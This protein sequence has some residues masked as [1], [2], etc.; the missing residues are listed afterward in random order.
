MLPFKVHARVYIEKL[1]REAIKSTVYSKYF[2][3]RPGTYPPPQCSISYRDE[4]IVLCRCFRP[5]RRWG[6]PVSSSF[7][8]V[9]VGTLLLESDKIAVARNCFSPVFSGC[10]YGNRRP[11]PFKSRTIDVRSIFGRDAPMSFHSYHV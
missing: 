2:Y 7:L 3:G 11:V 9:F 10:P 6:A 5:G 1:Q 8:F 4:T